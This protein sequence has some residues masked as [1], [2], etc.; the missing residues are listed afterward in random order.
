MKEVDKIKEQDYQPTKDKS[1]G[2]IALT[3]FAMFIGLGLIIGFYDFTFVTFLGITKVFLGFA[4]VGFI[5]PLKLYQRWFHFI[6]YEVIIFNVIGVGPLFSGLFFV[7]NF[8]FSHSPQVYDFEIVSRQNIN[9]K[10]VF[11]ISDEKP[12]LPEKAYQF[13]SLSWEEMMGKRTLEITVEKGAFGFEVIKER[14][15]K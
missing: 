15:F 11:Q 10:I 12:L 6:K 13:N 1:K 2:A 7:F 14:R 3:I 9:E 8:L 5:I 4:V